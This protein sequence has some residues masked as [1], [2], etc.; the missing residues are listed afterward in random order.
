MNSQASEP[1]KQSR[2]IEYFLPEEDK[3]KLF[4]LTGLEQLQSLVEGRTPPPPISSHIGLEIVS[5]A[6]GDVVMSALPDQSHYNPIGSVHGGFFATVLDSVAGCAVHSNL[7]AGV[8]YTSLELKVSFL[9]PITASTGLVTAHGWVTRRGRSATF[10]EA[11]IRDADGR[12]L[13]TA[14][15]TCLVIQSKSQS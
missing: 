1:V 6:D 9:R 13:A 14:S 7:P 11:D 2:T 12:V 5:L 4:A 10:A 15:T 8:G 3:A